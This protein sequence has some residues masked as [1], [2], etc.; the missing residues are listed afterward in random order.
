MSNA[1]SAVMSNENTVE[2]TKKDGKYYFDKITLTALKIE[3]V[4]LAGVLL[5]SAYMAVTTFLF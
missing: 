2:K 4:V 3:T 5:Y 1:S